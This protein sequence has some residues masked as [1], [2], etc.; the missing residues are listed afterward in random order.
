MTTHTIYLSLGSNI[1]ERAENLRRAITALPVNGMQVRRVSSFYETEPVD[2]LEQPWFL[3]CVVEAETELKPLPLMRAL[4]GIE[5]EMGGRKEFPRGPRLIDLDI[6]LYG[7]EAIEL[8]ELQVPHPRM[9]LRRFV[10]VPLAEI[11]ADVKHPVLGVSAA[12][13][14][15]RAVDDSVVRPYAA[16]S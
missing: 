3:N 13:L 5:G 14:L 7:Q 16:T 8:P 12:E 2:Y 10:L 1:G 6:L 11:A 9:H 4:R 15:A